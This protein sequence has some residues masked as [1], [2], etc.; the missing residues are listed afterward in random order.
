MQS[1]PLYKEARTQHWPQGATLAERLWGSKEE[2]LQ[3]A[4][5]SNTI[6]LDV[7]GQSWSADEEQEGGVFNVRYTRP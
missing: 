2:L 5:F 3:A 7:R 1:C 4:S 6:T